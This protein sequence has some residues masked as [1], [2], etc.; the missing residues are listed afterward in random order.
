MKF[1]F[2]DMKPGDGF[3][4]YITDDLLVFDLTYRGEI[5]FDTVLASLA[6]YPD[7]GPFAASHLERLNHFAAAVA[8]FLNA[9]GTLE[10]MTEVLQKMSNM[11][12]DSHSP[13]L[14]F[15]PYQY[16]HGFGNDKSHHMFLD[17]STGHAVEWDRF[18]FID[19]ALTVEDCG[20][21]LNGA[22]GN[23]GDIDSQDP[24]QAGQTNFRIDVLPGT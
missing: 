13:L 11:P 3:N 1:D 12:V 10:Q 18:L 2:K 5:V 22:T 23:T 19:M 21:D 8:E 16:L 24:G 6:D 20:V 4:A 17:P 9:E 15:S 7:C 14:D